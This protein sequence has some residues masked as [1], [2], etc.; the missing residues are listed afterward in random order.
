MKSTSV[1]TLIIKEEAIPADS[2][3]SESESEGS[4]EDVEIARQRY[5]A[6][7]RTHLWAVATELW[8]KYFCGEVRGGPW[9]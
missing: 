1:T 5:S 4:D 9:R 7:C 3:E 8:K 2:S 6:L